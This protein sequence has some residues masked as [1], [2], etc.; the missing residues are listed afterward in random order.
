MSNGW[1]VGV[2]ADLCVGSGLC[3]GLAPEHFQP[4]EDGSTESVRPGI[5][6]DDAVYDAAWGCPVE[7]ISI[8]EVD[9]GNVVSPN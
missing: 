3:Q 4:G 1:K 2:D 7:A 9:T 8:V 5:E 6:P